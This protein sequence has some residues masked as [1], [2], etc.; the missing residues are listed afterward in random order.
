[1]V[2]RLKLLGFLYTARLR[3]LCGAFALRRLNAEEFNEPLLEIG[4]RKELLLRGV[5]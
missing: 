3:W 1:M 5:H 2:L 4:N